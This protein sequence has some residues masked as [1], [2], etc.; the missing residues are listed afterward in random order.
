MMMAER[1]MTAPAA[2]GNVLAAF[3]TILAAVVPE[4]S[5]RVTAVA[6]DAETGRLD[7]VPGLPG[8]ATQLRWSAP[9]LI[10]AAKEKV[11]AANVRALNVLAPAPVKAAAPA[12]AA[13][14]PSPL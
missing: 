14:E 1:G 4:L 7:V 5:A 9:K 8:A 10:A 11:P 12:T 3:D 13:A 6:F 2:S